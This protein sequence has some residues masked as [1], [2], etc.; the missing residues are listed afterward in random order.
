VLF[1][2]CTRANFVVGIWA[3]KFAR[4][5]QFHWIELNWIIYYH[6][7]LNFS[8]WTCFFPYFPFIYF[9]FLC[10]N[11]LKQI[12]SLSCYFQV[13]YETVYLTSLNN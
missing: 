1:F 2:L 4:R 5:I 11:N 3:V 7:R 13:K 6:Y 10:K 12:F 9:I 8:A